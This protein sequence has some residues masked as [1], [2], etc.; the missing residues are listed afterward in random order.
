MFFK[1][2]LSEEI[3]LI[4]HEDQFLCGQIIQEQH[5]SN[6]LKTNSFRKD[7]TRLEM[8]FNQWKIFFIRDSLK[9][10]ICCYSLLKILE[11]EELIAVNLIF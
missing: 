10:N 3:L 7:T 8:N 1:Y 4:V 5:I 2:I 11:V 6:V 9:M